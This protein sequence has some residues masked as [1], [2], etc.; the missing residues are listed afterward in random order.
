MSESTL[1]ASGT[2]GWMVVRLGETRVALPIEAVGEVMPVPEL[3]RVPM[4]PPWVAGIV[5]VR[6]EVVPVVDAPLRVGG[7]AAGADRRL[8]LA[9]VDQSGEHVGLLVDGVAGLL[10]RT[11]ATVG[12]VP[13]AAR[14]IPKRFASAGVSRG[15]VQVPL[16]DLEALLDPA[17]ESA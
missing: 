1:I 13:A 14:S 4:A 9:T 17:V 8:V 6:G 3:S 2:P 16:L 11:G 5:N 10:E 15:D 7:T 12:D